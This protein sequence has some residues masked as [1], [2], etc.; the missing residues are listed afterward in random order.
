MRSK[1]AALE[2]R[3]HRY[4]GGRTRSADIRRRRRHIFSRHRAVRLRRRRRPQVPLDSDA[5][6]CGGGIR[7]RRRQSHSRVVGG[8]LDDVIP[9]DDERL[10]A[11]LRD[12]A[13]VALGVGDPLQRRR[14]PVPRQPRRRRR[15]RRRRR[16]HRRRRRRLGRAM[17]GRRLLPLQRRRLRGSFSLRQRD[18]TVAD[19]E[20]VAL[21]SVAT[22]RPLRT[23]GRPALVEDEEGVFQCCFNSHLR[24][25]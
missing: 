16:C 23:V 5:G 24:L 6:G 4:A 17:R 3:R 9:A 2:R 15:S 19:G 22:E 12:L 14:V 13:L 10:D 7:R 20:L 18:A 25:S 11:M 21:E 8:A 1:I